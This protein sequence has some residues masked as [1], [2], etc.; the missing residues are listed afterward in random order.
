MKKL[1][2]I[3]NYKKLGEI[4]LTVYPCTRQGLKVIEA[5]HIHSRDP[6][7]GFMSLGRG[8]TESLAI[9]ELFNVMSKIDEATR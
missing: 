1:I 5:V 3:D 8:S 2:K 9:D 6:H 7:V 4:Y